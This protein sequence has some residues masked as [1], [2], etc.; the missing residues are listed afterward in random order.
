MEC[1]NRVD[2]FDEVERIVSIW[3]KVHW[4]DYMECVNR[5]DAFDEVERIVSIW[6]KVHWVDCMECVNRVDAFDEVERTEARDRYPSS[7]VQ[8]LFYYHW[9]LLIS[10]TILS[11]FQKFSLTISPILSFKRIRRWGKSIA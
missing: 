9:K 2:A 4:V 1:V 11:S 3:S 5:V 8:S 7:D 10:D 6:S